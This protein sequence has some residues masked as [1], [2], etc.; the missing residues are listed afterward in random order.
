MPNINEIATYAQDNAQKLGIQK[1]DIY[2]STVDETSVQVDQG[3]P[4]Q[5]KA[6]NR[7][8]VTVRVWN[9]DNT[10]GITSTTDVDPKGLELA[11]KTAYEASFFGVK[12]NV[13]DFS[14]EATVPLANTLNEKAPQAPV[15][16]LIEKLL[17]AEK[18]LL[19]AHPA[20]KGVPYNGLAQRDIDRFYLNSQGALR[21]ESVSLSSVY[22]YS[23]TEEEGKK[24]RSAGAYRINRSLENLDINGCIQ[25][26]A[27][28]TISHLN[29]DKI[30]TG[31]YRV[32]FSPEAFLSLLGAF[33]NLF[34]AQNILD[35]QSLSTPDD[36]GKQ[37]ASPLLS[38]YDDALHPANIGAESFDGEGTPTRQIR[39][40]ENGILTG[41]LH[42]AGTAKR[43]NTQPTG[44]ASIGAKVSVSPN[45]Y[46]VFASGNS[47]E[48]FSLET[49][50]NVILIDDLHALHAGVKSL[51]GS[52]SLPF[53]GWLINK[54]VKTSI[55]S[56]TVAGDFLELLKSII[57]VEPEVALTPGGVAPKIWVEELSI[58]GE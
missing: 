14:P 2:G 33:S 16:E 50:D 47:E 7:S 43:L 11:L 32:I 53:D 40:I 44:N 31:K 52:F 45:F 1:F 39:L 25:E 34:N 17:V 20:I 38:V 21:T 41:F 55:E 36:L 37:I 29:Y 9:E 35:K 30:K 27:E 22:L 56:A 15:S 26:T 28:K 54:G 12:E 42:S 48:K 24:P 3:E 23:K 46:H 10:I 58:T 18:E 4:K 5:V 13:P 57:Y 49:A 6:S 8:G 51:Q 19:A